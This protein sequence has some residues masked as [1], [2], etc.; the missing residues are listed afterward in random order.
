[1]NASKL[2]TIFTLATL[3]VTLPLAAQP[4]NTGKSR[5]DQKTLMK[6]WALSICFAQIAEDERTKKDAGATA[7]AYLENSQQDMAA[8]EQ[9]GKL[10]DKYVQLKYDGSDK[11]N[12]NT[13]KCIDLFHS[14]ELDRLVSRY[15]KNVRPLG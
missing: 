8:F 6:N 3:L 4:A 10:V 9:I 15:V 1:M 11:A 13:M 14:K 12:Y 7:R 2:T 5:N